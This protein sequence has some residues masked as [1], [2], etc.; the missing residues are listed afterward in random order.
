MKKI[1][2]IGLLFVLAGTGVWSQEV[3]DS[4]RIHYRRGYRGVDPDYHNNRSEL[5]RF[6]RTL[7]R[8][9]ESARL[10]RVVICSW[11]SPDGV[12]RYNELLAGRRADSL[13][14]WLVRH[15]Q[16]P[17]ELVSVRGEGIAGA[18][19]GSWWQYPICFIRTKCYT[20]STILPCGFATPMAKS[21]TDARNS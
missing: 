18:Y 8:E 12:T 6:I 3:S 1:L 19:Y 11:T 14:S 15:A 10:E 16:I 21:W 20:S 7:R 4:V 2:F 17:G 9:Q 5:E 13:K